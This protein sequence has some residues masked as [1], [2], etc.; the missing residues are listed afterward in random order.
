MK[1]PEFYPIQPVPDSQLKYAVVAARYQGKWIFVRHRERTTWEIPGGHVEPGEAPMEAARRELYE[2]TGATDADIS[3]V[4]TYRLYDC[5]LLC[6]AEVHAL[7]PIPKDSE[8]AE[9]QFFDIPPRDLTYGEVHALLHKWVQG[10]LNTQSGAGEIWDVYDE[11]RNL[12][13]RTHRRGDPLMPGD[14][15]LTVH[16]WMLNSQ[17]KFLL[18]KRSPNKGFP[19]MWEP[20]GGSALAGDDSLTAALREVKEETGLELCPENGRIVLQ[21]SGPDFHEDVWLFHQD[22]RLSD[23]RLLEGETCDAMYAT[24]EVILKMLDDGRFVPLSHVK[25]LLE[26]AEGEAI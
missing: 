14:Y 3:I 10:W 21:N 19:N 20:T 17:G 12:T 1:Q 24:G 9:I 16:V 4:G 8:I 11:N 25:K 15:H 6:F 22:F 23:V 18:T 13:G 26:I 7:G 5:G 2:E